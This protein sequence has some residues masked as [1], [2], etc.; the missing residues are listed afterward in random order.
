M[1]IF[2]FSGY[3]N[4]CPKTS[5]GRGITMIYALVGIPLFL[6]WVA[7]MGNLFGS[8]FKVIYYK[9]CCGLCRRGKRR[10]ALALATKT[11]KQEEKEK[12]M[13][14]EENAEEAKNCLIPDHFF[15]LSNQLMQNF[16]IT[17]LQI[18]KKSDQ[19]FFNMGIIPKNSI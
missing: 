7:Q 18:S 15:F 19:I 8:S 6:L 16:K 11:K 1:V 9:I 13:M 4:I 5:L 14:A 2:L 10:K 17:N 3:G 12:A